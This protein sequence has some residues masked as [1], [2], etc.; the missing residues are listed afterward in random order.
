MQSIASLLSMK[1]VEDVGNLEDFDVDNSD[2]TDGTLDRHETT[3]KISELASQFGLLAEMAS[4]DDFEG[5]FMNQFRR[6][7]IFCF[8]LA[9]N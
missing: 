7:L 5:L 1:P 4:K 9:K 6:G 3:L 8:H 2:Q